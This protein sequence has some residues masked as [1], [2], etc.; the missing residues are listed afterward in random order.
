MNKK[1]WVYPLGILVAAFLVLFGMNR[2]LVPVEKVNAA[3]DRY[4]AMQLLL[5]GNET[6]EELEYDGEDGNI[7]RIYQAENGVVVE[8]LVAG[9][10]D[11]ITLLVG[12]DPGG[13][14]T[15]ILVDEMNETWGLGL[16]AMTDMTF[17]SQLVG[18]G[19]DAA[20]GE[21]IDAIS[22]ATV[23]SKAI[24]KAVNSAAAY[25]TGADISSGA[26]EWGG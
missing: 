21:N 7:V 18:T 10:V 24:V 12:V 25:V 2:L 20:V 23:T 16:R 26:T 14:V 5:P 4:T 6:F 11:D 1:E 9:Y 15:G 8:T 3:K 22:G 17:L 19:G 13:K